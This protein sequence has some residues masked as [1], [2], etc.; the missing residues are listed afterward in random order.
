[1]TENY[2]YLKKINDPDQSEKLLALYGAC[3]KVEEFAYTSERYADTCL[4][5]ARKA[6]ELSLKI[7]YEK[8]VGPITKEMDSIAILINPVVDIDPEKFVPLKS[9][10]HDVRRTGNHT[11][12]GD[13]K[14]TNWRTE[15]LKAAQN[16]FE[17]V[18]AMSIYL[19]YIEEAPAY[20]EPS[21]NG[22]MEEVQINTVGELQ[23]FFVV[24]SSSQMS[25][26]AIS[27]IN[28]ALPEAIRVANRIS[29]NNDIPLM[30]KQI[31][32]T[33]H[34]E[35]KD[36]NIWA[37]LKANGEG[38]IS[39][40]IALLSERINRNTEYAPIVIIVTNDKA[41]SFKYLS[42]ETDS[43]IRIG[44]SLDSSGS[45]ALKELVTKGS[46]EGRDGTVLNQI[47]MRFSYR[48]ESEFT[49]DLSSIVKSA[50]L[51]SFKKIDPPYINLGID[52][53][54]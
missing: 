36:V 33:N 51:S 34:A 41:P 7:L 44:I 47:E 14:I 45:D 24:D 32:V 35:M 12:H 53:T 52:T 10:M 20:K 42:T 8:K 40:G 30:M 46:V 22:T 18:T 26:L 17:I 28:S 4:F 3:E 49:K 39:S 21:G 38:S 29:K 23:L 2:E 43:M 50:L 6:L 9:K 11:V 5:Y 15:T 27:C 54:K 48:N 25:D 1:M 13:E 19:G 37:D 16:V 31:I